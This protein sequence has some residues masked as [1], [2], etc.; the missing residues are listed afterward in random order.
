MAHRNFVS[1]IP[2]IAK[3]AEY[4][5]NYGRRTVLTYHI[6]FAIAREKA[7]E[8]KKG[9]D[10]APAMQSGRRI[11]GRCK[12]RPPQISPRAGAKFSR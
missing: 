8:K 11:L 9:N 1:D 6:E 7:P 12:R 10:I 5:R 4:T 2:K 3:L